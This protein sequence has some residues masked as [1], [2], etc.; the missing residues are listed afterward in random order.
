VSANVD[1]NVHATGRHKNTP[2]FQR[3]KPLIADHQ[4]PCLSLYQPTFR[5]FPDIQQNPIRYRNLLRELK[6]A[7]EQKYPDTP[8]DSLLERF[9]RLADDRD[10]WAHPQDGIAVFAA[11]DFFHLEK[12]QRSVPELV[13][14][15]DHLNLRPLVRF[16]QS[17]DTYQILVVDRQRVRMYQ[18]NRYVLDEIVMAPSVPRT[19]EEALGEDIPIPGV[20]TKGSSGP[21]RP[22][23]FPASGEVFH[24]HGSKV[25]EP[26]DDV[27]RFF[28]VIDRAV[29]EA[30]SKPSELPLILAALPEYQTRFR[31]LSHNPY[32][33]EEGIAANADGLTTEELREAAWRVIEPRYH[34]RL[35]QI[36]D[37]YGAAKGRGLATD[38][39]T[40]AVEFA[41][42]GRVGTL[43]LEA[44]RR[45]PGR[46]EGRLPRVA[47]A[48]QP[49]AGD[50]LDELAERVLKTGGQVVVAPRASMPTHT[51]LAAVFR[52]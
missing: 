35:R 22:P 16:L 52:Y 11:P 4:P 7:L 13:V 36:H 21:G 14:V 43:L 40:H 48:D 33:V 25:E 15:D 24:G 6:A 3:L 9:E 50:I 19:I 12:L 1:A 51:G 46:I 27:E 31:A 41:V 45:L 30:H 29:M 5:A 23:S 34:A 18:G 2:A 47:E 10:F 38:D 26:W 37:A 20:H 39:L 8:A 17:A 32:L 44:D 28:R 49:G 42:D